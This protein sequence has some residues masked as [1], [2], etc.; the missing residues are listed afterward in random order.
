M[1]NIELDRFKQL[2]DTHGTA[3][4]RWPP[5]ER[6][7][8]QTL[9]AVSRAAQREFDRA[10]ELNTLL[11]ALP[12][13]TEHDGS[14]RAGILAS[15]GVND[16]AAGT[17]RDW[18]NRFLDWLSAGPWLLRPAA[19]AA[20]PLLVGLVLGL[21]LPQTTTDDQLVAAVSLLAY[22]TIDDTIEDY[23]DAQ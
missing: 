17:R 9:L 3:L 11:D 18:L 20:V 5:A 15:I 21:N 19:L 16:D 22:D 23:T 13:P 8:A 10:E 6:V 7:Q 1:S 14:L 2:L 4:E 12:L